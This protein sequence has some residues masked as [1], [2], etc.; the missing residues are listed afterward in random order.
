M[1]LWGAKLPDIDAKDVSTLLAQMTEAHATHKTISCELVKRALACFAQELDPS[2][3]YFLASELDPWL[4]PT[5]EQLDLWTQQVKEENFSCFCHIHACMLAAIERRSRYDK[6]IENI[7][8]PD[9][10]SIKEFKDIMWAENETALQERLLKIKYLQQQALSKL[11]KEA[12]NKAQARITKHRQAREEEIRGD[13]FQDRVKFIFC[14]TVKAFATSFDNHTCY[15]TPA[16]AAQFLIQMQQR[17]VGIGA[18]LRDDLTGFSIVSIIEGG[19][20][21]R[22]KDIKNGDR[23]I[24]INGEPVVGLEITEAVELIRGEEGTTV[25]LTVLREENEEEQRYEIDITRGEVVLKEARIESSTLPFG[26]GVIAVIALH[27]FY[28]D[29]IH[30][31]GSDLYEEITKIRKDHKLK[32]LILDLRHNAGGVLPQ[33]VTVT[34]LFITK[35]IVVSIKDNQDH[36]EH[37]RELDGKMAYDGPLIVL[38]SKASA[39]AAEIVAQTL[40]DYGRAIV[41]GDE[42]TFGKGTFQTFSLDSSFSS[43]INPKGELKVTRGRYYTVSGKSPQLVGVI[44]DIIVPGILSKAEIGEQYSSYPLETDVI[45]ENFQDDLADIPTLQ[46]EHI[47]W[48]YRFNLQAKMKMYSRFLPLL[49]ENSR[50][51]SGNDIFYQ[52]FL[53]DLDQEDLDDVTRQVYMQHDFQLHETVNIMRDLILLLN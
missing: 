42:H 29:P 52:K 39:S 35:G 24:A 16:E 46:R 51:R 28:Q 48:L 10:V 21:S 41:V 11:D 7:P 5:Q 25:H 32:G 13:T 49:Q 12:Y 15:F 2:K 23:I 40:Q 44:P 4:H 3:T 17:L 19:P 26:D 8:L 50:Q 1:P 18:Q 34:G 53:S 27:T 47:R 30:S 6:L 37:L 36:I 22:N 38:T 9:Q 45:S 14:H 33:A 31:S 43:K 20:A